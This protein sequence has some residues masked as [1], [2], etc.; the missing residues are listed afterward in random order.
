MTRPIPT[1]KYDTLPGQMAYYRQILERVKTVSG[2]KAAAIV[3]DLPLSGANTSL[4]FDF[5]EPDRESQVTS[6]RTISPGYFAVRH[7]AG[8]RP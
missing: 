2:I 6:A 5:K 8:G 4:D 3:N 1:G 7:P